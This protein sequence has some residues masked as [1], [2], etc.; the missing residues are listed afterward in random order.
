[1]GLI[2]REIEQSGIPTLSMSSAWDVTFAV[3]PPRSVF[4][5]FPLNHETGKANDPALQRHILLDA[6]QAF[7]TLWAPGMIVT[8]PYVWDK[9]DR[10]WE[11][12]DYGPSA[13]G[14]GVGRSVQEGF[15]ERRLRRAEH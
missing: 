14:Y 11:D 8:L 4:I 2:A 9:D 5:N 3:R 13:T 12:V 10:R 1:M 15:A 6:F 7:E